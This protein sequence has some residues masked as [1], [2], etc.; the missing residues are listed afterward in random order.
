MFSHTL[1]P[2]Q[3]EMVLLRRQVRAFCLICQSYLN[4]IS[5]T[6]KE[7]VS[8]TCHRPRILSCIWYCGKMNDFLG[9]VLAYNC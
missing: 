1:V 8:L 6:V 7:Q 4:S 9:A 2:F 5:T 3:D